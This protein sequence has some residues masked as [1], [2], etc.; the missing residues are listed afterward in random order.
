[1]GVL[2]GETTIPYMII[3][4][5]GATQLSPLDTPFFV[6]IIGTPGAQENFRQQILTIE[7]F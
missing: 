3:Q 6:Y 5:S 4:I 1:M 2:S 7:M